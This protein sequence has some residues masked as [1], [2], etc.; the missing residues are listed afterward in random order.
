MSVRNSAEK[1][2]S[3]HHRYKKKYLA[4]RIENKN[5]YLKSSEKAFEFITSYSFYQG[6]R[7]EVSEDFEEKA[8]AV[9]IPLMKKRDIFPYYSKRIADREG[10]KKKY[11]QLYRLLEDGGVNKEGDRLMVVSI[12]NFIQSIEEQNIL[13]R[14]IGLI[15][16]RR[17][18]EAYNQLDS[19]WSIGPKIASLILRDIV[20]IYEL[21][22]YLEKSDYYYLQPVDT[23]VH[24]ISKL[25]RLVKEDEIYKEESKDIVD[26]CHRMKVNPIHYNQGAWYLATNSH[27]I[28][29]RN[30][31]NIK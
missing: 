9:M 21:E 24:Q 18:A 5:Q 17:V 10:L 28:I 23:W 13:A 12:V 26:K 15:R 25:I 19:I 31:N 27:E 7:D 14:L 16:S 8:K 6:R 3:F 4:D 29:L 2:S 1:I 11:S 20:Y 30:I 22:K